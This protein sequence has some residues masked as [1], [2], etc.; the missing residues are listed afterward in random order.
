MI[1]EKRKFPLFFFLS[2]AADIERCRGKL[3]SSAADC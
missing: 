2:R 1:A 3:V